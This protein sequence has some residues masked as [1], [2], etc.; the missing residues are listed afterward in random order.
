MGQKQHK[1]G[2]KNLIIE[3]NPINNC[4]NEIYVY[5]FKNATNYKKLI[6][7]SILEEML[8]IKSK[9]NLIEYIEENNEIIYKDY[10]SLILS[11]NLNQKKY[12][13]ELYNI[14]NYKNI[15]NLLI[16][17]DYLFISLIFTSLLSAFQYSKSYSYFGLRLLHFLLV[18]LMGGLYGLYRYYQIVESYY[19]K[20]DYKDHFYYMLYFLI[21]VLINVICF[22]GLIFVQTGDTE[23]LCLLGSLGLQGSIIYFWVQEQFEKNT[24]K[25]MKKY[26]Y[27]VK[28]DIMKKIKKI[29][30]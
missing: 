21:P 3:I 29:K 20:F 17:I 9:P 4:Y 8:K 28:N 16:K 22:I 12:Q 25:Q 14:D 19:Y 23:N 7:S 30:K 10:N 18:C 5:N 24:Y 15:V 6:S 27:E 11:F 26:F 1:G 2:N 13:I